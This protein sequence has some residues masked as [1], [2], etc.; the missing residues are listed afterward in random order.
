MN[1][2]NGFDFLSIVGQMIDFLRESI[3]QVDGTAPIWFN[4]F[5]SFEGVNVDMQ[6]ERMLDFLPP[7]TESTLLS[8]LI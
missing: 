7:R 5:P 2:D 1:S 3:I 8:L 6:S 4:W